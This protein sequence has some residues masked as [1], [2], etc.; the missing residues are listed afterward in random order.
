MTLTETSKENGKE[1]SHYTVK[2][3]VGGSRSRKLCI[4]AEVIRG[5]DEDAEVRMRPEPVSV[6]SELPDV[7][8]PE[9][10]ALPPEHS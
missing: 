1:R 6:H 9:N 7:F 10:G 2:K 5:V 4:R 3:M 8:A